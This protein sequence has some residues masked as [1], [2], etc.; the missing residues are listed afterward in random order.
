MLY[1]QKGSRQNG[2]VSEGASRRQRKVTDVS[3]NEPAAVAA[4]TVSMS[5]GIAFV[6]HQIHLKA[7]TKTTA[8]V[9][10][11]LLQDSEHRSSGGQ[12]DRGGLGGPDS[13]DAGGGGRPEETR[14]GGGIGPNVPDD[15]GSPR[16]SEGS[17]VVAGVDDDDGDQSTRERIARCYCYD[18]LPNDVAGAAGADVGE[19][20]NA[21]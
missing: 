11:A 5:M 6:E 2:V 12:H 7:T 13:L 9:V 18:L 19:E 15:P 3:R 20:S 10:V 1:P 14:D 21:P 8:E 4:R 17:G 16:D